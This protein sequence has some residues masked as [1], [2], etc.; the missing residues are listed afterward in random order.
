MKTWPLLLLLPF[1]LLMQGTYATMPFVIGI[2][3]LYYVFAKNLS[4]FPLAWISGIIL[5]A[6]WVQAI[7][8][9]SLFLVIFLYF[10]SVYEKKFEIVTVPFIFFSTF[11]G[12]F[13]FLLFF[14]YQYALLQACINSVVAALLFKVLIY[15]KSTED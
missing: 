15:K 9:T 10:V 11:L 1:A 13:V 8:T 7:G 4:V 3:L 2:L 5:D 12:S 6:F 14:D